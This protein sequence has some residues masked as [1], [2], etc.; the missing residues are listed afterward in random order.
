MDDSAF[1]ESFIPLEGAL[2][3]ECDPYGIPL[4]PTNVEMPRVES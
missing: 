3:P 2:F 4:V 1:D